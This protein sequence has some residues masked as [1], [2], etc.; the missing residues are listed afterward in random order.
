MIKRIKMSTTRR[1]HSDDF[2]AKVALELIRGEKSLAEVASQYEI[3]P[4]LAIKWKREVEE[5]AAKLFARKEDEQVKEL[6][7]E[8]ERLYKAI[9]KR[10]IENDWLKKKL[11]L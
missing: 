8:N 1:S 10:Q 9:G 4:N 3:H 5:K 2:K 11:G 7:E 6:K